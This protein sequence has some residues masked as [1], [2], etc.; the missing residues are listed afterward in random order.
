MITRNAMAFPLPIK[1]FPAFI[2]PKLVSTTSQIG[3]IYKGTDPIVVITI[4]T[5]TIV[6]KILLSGNETRIF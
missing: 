5:L 1:Y 2:E 3:L 4:K 6:P